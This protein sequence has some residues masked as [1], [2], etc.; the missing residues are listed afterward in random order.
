MTGHRDRERERSQRAHALLAAIGDRPR[1]ARY[2]SQTKL[3]PHLYVLAYLAS[4]GLEFALESR[5][6]DA[7]ELLRLSVFNPDTYLVQPIN[8][9]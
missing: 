7:S 1:I 6:I 9:Y 4:F 3:Q 8:P 5:E 2:G